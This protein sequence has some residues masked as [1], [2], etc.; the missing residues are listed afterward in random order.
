MIRIGQQYI[1]LNLIYFTISWEEGGVPDAS[2]SGHATPPCDP[3]PIDYI[4]GEA[5]SNFISG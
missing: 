4:K 5:H 2:E 1:F 3:S